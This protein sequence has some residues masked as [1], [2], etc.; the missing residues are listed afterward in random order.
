MRVTSGAPAPG[1]WV[2]QGDGDVAPDGSELVLLLP[3]PEDFHLLQRQLRGEGH[4]QE[5]GWEE[6]GEDGFSL[7]EDQRQL[8]Y[9]W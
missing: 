1:P 3:L 5:K 7:L 8:E 4:L 2:Q 6:L 9:L